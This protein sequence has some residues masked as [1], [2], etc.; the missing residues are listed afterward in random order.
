MDEKTFDRVATTIYEA[1]LG[2]YIGR[3][4]AEVLAEFAGE[5]V[6]L[7]DK[8]FL[9]HQGEFA[10]TFY[11]VTGG[12]LAFVREATA[13]KPEVIIHVLEKGDLCGEM[14]F[15]DGGE[16]TVSCCALGPAAVLSFRVGD[17]SPL[18]EKHPRVLYDF[19]RAVI[20]RAHSTSASLSRQRQELADFIATGGKRG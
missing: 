14:S 6:T 1:P 12:R 18:V 2:T 10:R 20:A 4:G 9:F 19:M 11:I 15:I 13:S 16:Y 5:E 8:E 17:L 3:E 7:T